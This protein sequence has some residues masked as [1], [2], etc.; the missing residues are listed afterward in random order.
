MKT[1]PGSID[2]RSRRYSDRHP[3]AGRVPPV[4]I[5]LIGLVTAVV[6][7][8]GGTAKPDSTLETGRPVQKHDT[9]MGEMGHMG[10]TGEMGHMG[11]MGKMGETGEMGEMA[12]MP[13]EI[14]KFHDTLAPRW[15][16]EHGPQR[17]TDTC[18]AIPQLH[19][20]ADAIVASTPPSGARAADW[21]ANARQLSDAVAALEATCKASDAAAFEQAFTAVHNHFHS[22]MAAA[23][24]SHDE[25][26]KPEGGEHDHHH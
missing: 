21:S 19:A 24:G 26:A 15:H 25:H 16:A 1:A 4:T 8:C 11:Q 3:A 20:D 6:I 12:A 7:G 22:L 18:A 2:S 14:K 9:R 23:G 10:E 13:P 5:A 17:M